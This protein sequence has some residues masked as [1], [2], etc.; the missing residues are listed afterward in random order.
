MERGQ[1]NV[2]LAQP[3]YLLHVTCRG[4]SLCGGK[5]PYAPADHFKPEAAPRVWDENAERRCS[6]CEAKLAEMEAVWSEGWL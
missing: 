1:S 2:G 3:R 5:G 4:R 6:T